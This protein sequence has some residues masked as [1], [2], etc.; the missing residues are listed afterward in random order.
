VL[1]I[2]SYIYFES[3]TGEIR[4]GPSPAE[5]AKNNQQPGHA[6]AES[7]LKVLNM[8]RRRPYMTTCFYSADI[9]IYMPLHSEITGTKK[10][11][12]Y[13]VI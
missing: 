4:P 11:K 13:T 7:F 10:V 5:K 8:K 2:I 9:G 3:Y 6:V 1:P 12:T